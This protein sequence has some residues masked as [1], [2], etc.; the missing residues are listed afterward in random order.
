MS[1]DYINSHQVRKS[2]TRASSHYDDH[3]VLQREIGDRLDAHLNFVKMQ[4]KRVLDIGCG[5]GYF[6][7]LLRQRYKK[8]ELWMLDVSGSMLEQAKLQQTRRFPWQGKNHYVQADAQALPFDSG[9]FDLVT[10]NLTMQWV[11]DPHKMMQ[12]MR[13]VLAPQG[14]ILFSTFGRRTLIELRQCLA[15]LKASGNMLAFPDVTSLGNSL[16][17]LA[18]EDPV[19][20]SDLFTLEYPDV[21]AL[22]RELKG[23]GASSSAIQHR[24]KGLYGRRLLRQLAEEYTYANEKGGVN[25]SFEAL[26]AQAWYKK[27]NIP[28][29]AE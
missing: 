8:S 4:P 26:Y 5:T 25:A 29:Y 10:S 27:E 28:I 12:E 18:L 22:V 11:I 21:M 24:Q 23:M 7:R 13:R 1:A 2:F 9:Q 15:T 14:M 20:D 16:Q 6:S 19:S 3:A 17:S